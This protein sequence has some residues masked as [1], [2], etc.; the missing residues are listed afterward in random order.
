MTDFAQ[1]GLEIDSTTAK[2]A[3]ESLDEL[4]ASSQRA[5]AALSKQ[6][7]QWIAEGKSL[8]EMR[9]RA[10]DFSASL[11]NNTGATSQSQK[12]TERYMATLQRQVDT[13]GMSRAQL[14]AY[15][16]G[17]LQFT[18]TQAEV[19]AANLQ[20]LQS[21]ERSGDGLDALGLKSR[22]ARDQLGLLVRDMLRG[23]FSQVGNR[24]GT[25]IAQ[26]EV[27]IGVLL[28]FL[29]PVAGVV[30][31]IV[32]IGKAF[33]DGEK[34]TIA[35]NNA[36]T[37]SGNYAGMTRQRMLDLAQAVEESGNLTISQSKA[38]VQQM[39][40]SGQ[41]SSSSINQIASL[42]ENFGRA[43]GKE[44]DK[45]GMDLVKIFS[46]PARGAEELNKQMNFLS[47]AEL[48]RIQYLT[49]LGRE[50]EAQLIL[51][52]KLAEKLRGTEENLG[53]L[54]KS[55]S[56]V[57]RTAS[58][59]WDAMLN[60]G[61]EATL[62]K[63]LENARKNL[64]QIRHLQANPGLLAAFGGSGTGDVGAAESEVAR[65]EA[66]VSAQQDAA[67]EAARRVTAEREA[68]K[69]AEE[70]K[71]LREQEIQDVVRIAEAEHQGRNAAIQGRQQLGQITQAQRDQQLLAS[72]LE[73]AST[74]LIA[75]ERQRNTENI[76]RIE[77][78]RLQT[79]ARLIDI[80]RRSRI[81]ETERA[82]QLLRVTQLRLQ[83]E[84][85]ARSIQATAVGQFGDIAQLQQGNEQLRQ[86][87]KELGK[88]REEI[89]MLRQ[90]ML[91]MQ[92]GNLDRE[93]G[94]ATAQGTPEDD[95]FIQRLLRQIE[96]LHERKELERSV[97]SGSTRNAEFEADYKALINARELELLTESEYDEAELELRTRHEA[98]LL[99][100]TSKAAFDRLKLTQMT[101]SQQVAATIG[102]LESMTAAA[103]HHSR[104]MFEIHKIAS[105]ANAVVKGYEAVQGAYAWGNTVGGPYFGAAMAALAFAAQAV[106]VSAIASSQ[107]GGGAGGSPSFGAPAQGQAPQ[108]SPISGLPVNQN[109]TGIT[110]HL[111]VNGH[112]LDVQQF[113]DTIMVPALKDAIDNRDVTVIGR[114]SRQAAE[115][116]S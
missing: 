51:A 105:L 34:E 5:E 29:A 1:L 61:R 14:A 33:N 12:E 37:V 82:E 78:A 97:D 44:I 90:S 47:V 22:R 62:E 112:I 75:N 23:D 3:A 85:D 115:L 77:M 104:A 114:N 70:Q 9:K 79:E 96:L 116:T 101:G 46:D 66:L 56:F 88:T 103:A 86:R 25:F 68:H 69:L 11:K 111:T 64:D 81:E 108:T 100:I 50:G 32:A 63:Q 28:R 20:V 2:E 40:A 67:E 93:I 113:T 94:E 15:R 4:T 39:V 102:Y 92:I 60:I 99:G 59:A 109:G 80:N 6:E 48:K 95:P 49:E 18:E 73:L 71:K 24:L 55:W 13:F 42:A 57:R 89:D 76:G 17:Q 31:S 19:V 21:M 41:I 27:G 98:T 10:D 110:L 43:T 53:T 26:S 36:L 52:E 65:L 106:Q 72:D 74:K 16:A 54:E 8:D 107:F 45:V 91:D 30:G 84:A 35:F 83:A 87:Q 58:S 38:I 7:Q